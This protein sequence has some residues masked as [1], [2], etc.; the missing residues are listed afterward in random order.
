MKEK[1]QVSIEFIIVLIV[2]LGVLLFS[3]AAYTEKNTGYI[4]SMENYEAKLVADKLARAINAVHLAGPGS[5]ATVLLEERDN[6][7]LG[8][9][10][11]AV[12]AA[13]RNNYVDSALL[14]RNITSVSI[15][16]G[17]TVLV[18]NV[19]GT[20]LA[21]EEGLVSYWA[22][23]EL[24][25]QTMVDSVSQKHGTAYGATLTEGVL[26][27]GL[28]F[29]GSGSYVEL[30]DL[31]TTGEGTLMLWAKPAS[32]SSQTIFDSS[33]SSKYFFIDI[34]NSSNLRFFLEDSSD[35]DFQDA[36]YNVSDLS[37]DQWY[38]IAAVWRYNDSPAAKL[39]LNGGIVGSDN[40]V[41]RN[42]ANF[43]NPYLGQTRN[44]YI[45]NWK[46]EGSLDELKLYDRE[47][48]ADEIQAY[49]Y[50][51]RPLD[52]AGS[53]VG[54]VSH[55]AMDSLESSVVLD[56]DGSNHGT[57]YNVNLVA[58]VLGNALHF[59]GSTSYVS[60][61][62]VITMEGGTLMLWAKPASMSSQTIFDSSSSSKYFFI[63]LDPSS[64]LRFWTED[65]IDRDFQDASYDVSGLTDDDWYHIAAVWHYNDS[66]AT[67]L[68]LD[69]TLV[70]SDTDTPGGIADFD[71]VY[72][73]QTR[74]NY[75][76][77]WQFEGDLD[78]VRLYNRRLSAEEIQTYYES[79]RP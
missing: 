10:R 60:L 6:F 45:T 50:S 20:I 21:S 30:P 37:G 70:D 47:L 32:V 5:E 63:D 19:N 68:Y 11:N 23:N 25:E 27:S 35:A 31:I 67:E 14:T 44:N 77:L 49:Y 65:S 29:D 55:W 16:P 64:H 3:L 74:N 66:P 26:G 54:L 2:L 53:T 22:M 34:D 52:A 76:T 79:T 46:F 71:S 9:S 43:D 8:I 24:Y 72:L 33:S 41:S 42:I 78:E 57:G 38:H 62:D 51:T 39:Y 69:G 61:P 56:S 59:D 1:G 17:Q 28:Y 18:K 4:Y 75:I 40:D 58:G 73:G 15:K 13:W 7:N 12:F 36:R 48:S